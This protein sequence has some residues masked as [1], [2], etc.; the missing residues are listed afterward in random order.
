[1]EGRKQWCIKYYDRSIKEVDSM[2]L[3]RLKEFYTKEINDNTVGQQKQK[4]QSTPDNDFVGIC[5]S[6]MCE[7]VA[8][9]G[10]VEC[11][12]VSD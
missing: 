4:S 8:F 7:G 1:M 12:F 9:Y 10:T 6:F 11:C 3:S 2:E 5:V